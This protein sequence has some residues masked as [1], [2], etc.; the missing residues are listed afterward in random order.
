[1]TA[2]PAPECSACLLGDARGCAV[3]TTS[4]PQRAARC[5]R[6]FLG[7]SES[8]SDDDDD[9]SGVVVEAIF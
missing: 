5:A 7:R 9:D 1:M 2:A 3:A 4:A 8:S 6:A